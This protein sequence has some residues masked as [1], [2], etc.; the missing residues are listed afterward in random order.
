MGRRSGSRRFLLL[1]AAVTIAACQATGGTSTPSTAPSATDV[2]ASIDAAT[3]LEMEAMRF[4]GEFGFPATLADVRAVAA[5]PTSTTEPF[6][7]PM[8]PSEIAEMERRAVG[9]EVPRLAISREAERAP[10]DFCGSYIDQQHGGK[11][12][13][14]WRANL[15]VH[16][17][18]IA[19]EAKS[20]EYLAFV[21]CRYSE[22]ELR[23]LSERLLDEALKAWM[24]TIPAVASSWGQDTQNNRISMNISSAVPGA[25]EVV[26]QHIL[27]TFDLP[28]GILVVQSD[29]NGAAL[30]PWGTVRIFVTRKDGKVV[31]ENSL[32][33]DWRPQDL[34]N[35]N[36]G[37]GDMGFGVPWTNEPTEL[38]CQEGT[39]RIAVHL[40]GDEYGVGMVSVKGG[41][42][43]D[44]KIVLTRDPPPFQG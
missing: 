2:T 26:R 11:V 20:L 22:N 33:F 3:P 17:T 42:N 40:F 35:L 32:G 14:M 9:S 10:N 25:A 31:G 8:L 21:S 36:C 28:P 4:R 7:I 1:I 15:H 41:Q 37:I 27:A 6:G 43:V 5:D 24:R 44:L 34:P 39:W 13:S 30:R 29:G 23:A 38:P 12:V 16:A 19:L 18:N